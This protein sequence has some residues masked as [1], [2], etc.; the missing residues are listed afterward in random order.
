MS[1]ILVN[2]IKDT[3]NN[4]LLSSDGSGSVTLGSTFPQNTPCFFASKNG[5]QSVTSGTITKVTLDVEIT[6]TD[7]AFSD[8]KF[9]VP[10][11]KGGLYFIVASV[12]SFFTSSDGSRIDSYIYKNGSLHIRDLNNIENNTDSDQRHQRSVT[13]AIVNLSEGDYLELYGL[14]EGT[15]PQFETFNYSGTGGSVAGITYL[16]GYRLIGA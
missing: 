5:R 7:N 6:D 9:T 14:L 10:T 1:N 16:M 3:G 12:G 11:G 13:Q 2:T 15:S 8:S 4:T